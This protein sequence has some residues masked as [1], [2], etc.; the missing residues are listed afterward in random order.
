MSLAPALQLDQP[1]R[2]ADAIA[3]G[4]SGREHLASGT[5]THLRRA[6]SWHAALPDWYILGPEASAVVYLGK[7]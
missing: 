2:T 7:V 1:G 3:D 5:G 6:D 4:R